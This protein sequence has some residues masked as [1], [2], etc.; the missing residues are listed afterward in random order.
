MTSQIAVE[1]SFRL[2]L[3]I[4]LFISLSFSS[5]RIEPNYRRSSSTLESTIQKTWTRRRFYPKR[6][7]VLSSAKFIHNSNTCWHS[8][9]GNHVVLCNNNNNNNKRTTEWLSCY[10]FLFLFVSYLADP[11][12]VDLC[13]FF[14]HFG[15]RCRKIRRHCWQVRRGR[16]EIEPLS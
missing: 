7:S 14:F 5:N 8:P 2:H 4:Y 1:I 13:F 11:K 15:W 12:D 16:A 3:F 6:R 9:T 10:V